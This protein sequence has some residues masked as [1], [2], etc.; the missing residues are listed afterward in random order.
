M[1]EIEINKTHLN[2]SLK[3]NAEES[4]TISNNETL[5]QMKGDFSFFFSTRRETISLPDEVQKKKIAT[6]S[7]LGILMNIFLFLYIGP[8]P[9]SEH[10]E[11]L[12]KEINKHFYTWDLSILAV[13]SLF[14]MLGFSRR[15]ISNRKGILGYKRLIGLLLMLYMLNWAILLIKVD[16]KHGSYIGLSMRT[17]AIAIIVLVRMSAQKLHFI[18]EHPDKF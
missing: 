17:I 5:E 1:H 15:I 6:F 18:L 11:L 10:Y 7:F 12:E 9:W 14:L 2:D 8:T 16:I 4:S 3:F 13:C